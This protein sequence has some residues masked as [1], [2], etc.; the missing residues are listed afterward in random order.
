MPIQWDL[1]GGLASILGCPGLF[2]AANSSRSNF[3]IG[4]LS[5]AMTTQNQNWSYN[6]TKYQNIFQKEN[7]I[8]IHCG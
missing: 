4:S 5:K 6:L 7:K 1:S 2:E 8:Y 3:Q